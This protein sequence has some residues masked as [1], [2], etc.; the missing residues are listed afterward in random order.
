MYGAVAVDRKFCPI[1][2]E[3][4]T[5]AAER[6]AGRESSR[7]S[8]ATWGVVEIRDRTGAHSLAKRFRRVQRMVSASVA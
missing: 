8:A 2:A 6:S 3:S 1:K 7:S 4:N 5:V